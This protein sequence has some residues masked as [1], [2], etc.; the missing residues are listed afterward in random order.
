M[1]PDIAAATSH[2]IMTTAERTVAG[3]IEGWKRT[4]PQ[5]RDGQAMYLN[6]VAE[7]LHLMKSRVGAT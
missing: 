7:L 6:A 5:D 1:D 3:E 4:H 2:A